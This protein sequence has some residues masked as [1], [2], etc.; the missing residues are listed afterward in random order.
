[1]AH[2]LHEVKRSN[3]KLIESVLDTEHGF[4][5]SHAEIGISR[6]K[7]S[8]SLSHRVT[9]KTDNTVLQVGLLRDR[10]TNR[11]YCLIFSRS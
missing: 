9:L 7:Y 8:N 5:D 2:S 3:T 4:R 10:T 6:E 11:F 1:M